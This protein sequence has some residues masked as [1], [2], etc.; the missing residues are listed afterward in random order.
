MVSFRNFIS[1]LDGSFLARHAKH[2]KQDYL[3]VDQ[4]RKDLPLDVNR[5]FNE[6]EDKDACLRLKR[7]GTP[8]ELGCQQAEGTPSSIDDRIESWQ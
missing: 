4:P 2:A 3:A 5:I 8:L 1:G 7:V 6:C